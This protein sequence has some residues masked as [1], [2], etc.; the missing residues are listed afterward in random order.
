MLSLLAIGL[1]AG[2]TAGSAGN[3]YLHQEKIPADSI[4]SLTYLSDFWDMYYDYGYNLDILSEQSNKPGPRIM[5]ISVYR[6]GSPGEGGRLQ[7]SIFLNKNG[8]PVLRISP[9]ES[10]PSYTYYFYDT[11]GD[12]YLDIMINSNKYDTLY[13]LR[14]FDRYHHA[15]KTIQYNISRK[16]LQFFTVIDMNILSDTLV[17]LKLVRFDPDVDRRK[18]LPF[19]G[20]DMLVSRAGDS[21]LSVH[22]D[23]TVYSDSSYNSSYTDL[24]RI[25]NNRLVYNKMK[26]RTL[27]NQ[28][29]NWIE[30]KSNDFN[31][32]RRFSYYDPDEPDITA[33]LTVSDSVVGFLYSQMDSLPPIAW[34]NYRDDNDSLKARRQI[35]DEG[36]YG[37]SISLTEGKNLEDFLPVLWYTVSVGSGNING[38]D[39]TCYAVGYNTPVSNGGDNLRCLAIYEHRNGM[40]RLI[41]QSFGALDPFYDADNDLLY[42]RFDE[43]NYSISIEEGDIFVNYEYMRGEASNVYAFKDGEWVLVYYSSSHRTCCQAEA[44]SYDYS[45]KTYSYSLYNMGDEDDEENADMPR[46]TTITEIQDRPVIYMDGMEDSSTELYDTTGD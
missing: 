46:D 29:G 39:S 4:S 37:D 16:E 22:T 17:Q 21:L 8:D 20:R 9:Y 26:C 45:T 15:R 34:E 41:K 13:T 40:Y 14:Q 43:T 38:F 42:D 44:I 6:P 36:T 5:T 12:R 24:Y 10:G 7:D 18:V 25:E 35:Y 28:Q 30:K 32:I 1:L 31:L 3:S 33:G 19:E 23:R 27:Y 2:F 11:K